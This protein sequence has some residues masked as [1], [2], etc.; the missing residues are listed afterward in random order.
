MK[1]IEEVICKIKETEAES[2]KHHDIYLEKINELKSVCKVGEFN[3]VLVNGLGGIGR[4]SHDGYYIE[5]K[6]DSETISLDD[7]T[8]QWLRDSKWPDFVS[9][10]KLI[11]D[12]FYDALREKK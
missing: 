1:T 8:I 4:P 9:F 7:F 12:K 10:C 2:R 6:R 3:I 11:S 5:F